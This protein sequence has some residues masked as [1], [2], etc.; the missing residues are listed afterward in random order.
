MA[1]RRQM[2]TVLVY[3]NLNFEKCP[4]NE[5]SDMEHLTSFRDRS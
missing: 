1:M 2:L 5:R 4:T 3:M